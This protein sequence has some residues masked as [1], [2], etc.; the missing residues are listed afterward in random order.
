M[1][2]HKSMFKASS[3]AFLT[4][5]SAQLKQPV[6][7]TGKQCRYCPD[8]DG[9]TALA[10]IHDMLHQHTLLEE[11]QPVTQRGTKGALTRPDIQVSAVA[12]CCS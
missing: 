2:S 9:R 8:N 11:G 6:T 12:H 10:Y 7:A 5:A 4:T 3:L 1:P